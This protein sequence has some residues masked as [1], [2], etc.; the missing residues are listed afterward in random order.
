MAEG[1]EIGEPQELT[2]EVEALAGPLLRAYGLTLVDLEF[3]RQGR[4]GVLRLFID[5]PG[6]VGIE[7]CRRLSE[8]LGDLLDVSDLIPES[9]DLEVSSPGLDRELRKEREFRWAVG[10]RVRLWTRE[11]LEGRREL[12][13]RLRHVTEEVLVVEEGAGA[14]RVE[15]P[16]VLLAKAR[17]EEV[18]GLRPAR[19]R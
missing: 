14:R 5:K 7:D 18:P 16:R 9:Y 8:E 3:R 1:K 13:G 2:A 15:V 11:A 4:R 17:L 6:G 10:K 12:A 19:H